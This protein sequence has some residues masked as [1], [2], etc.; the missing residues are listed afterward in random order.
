M[1]S[2]ILNLKCEELRLLLFCFAKSTYYVTRKSKG[3]VAWKA[4]WASRLLASE[5]NV[6]TIGG[7]KR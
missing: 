1:G 7:E 3:V 6:K 4:R 2:L 5:A